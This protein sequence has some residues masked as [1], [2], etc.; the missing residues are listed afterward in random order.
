M[1]NETISGLIPFLFAAL[2]AWR[3]YKR[4]SIAFKVGYLAGRLQKDGHESSPAIKK[5][6]LK[7]EIKNS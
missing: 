1:T 2:L 3:A 5:I 4:S 6:M 7:K